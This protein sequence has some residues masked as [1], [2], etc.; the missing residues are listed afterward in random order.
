MNSTDDGEERGRLIR[1]RIGDKKEAR[2][3]SFEGQ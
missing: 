2:L 3:S 1:V